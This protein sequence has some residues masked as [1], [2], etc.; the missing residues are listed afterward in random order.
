MYIEELGESESLKKI[1]S[2]MVL[3][4]L[5]VSIITLA[6]ELQPIKGW[7]GTVCIRADGSIDP[8]DAPIITYDRITYTLTDNITSGGD[9]IIVERDNIIIDGNGFT[10][11]GWRVY[12]PKGIYLSDSVNV[13]AQKIRIKGFCYGIYLNYSSS[14]SIAG[15]GITESLYTGIVLWDSS[16]YNS[17]VGNNI[18]AIDYDGIYVANS[19]NNHISR[20][21][22]AN[23]SHSIYMWGTSSNSTIYHNNFINTGPAEDPLGYK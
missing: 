3:A 23:N 19:S 10:L 5:L 2:G 11:E 7:T 21:N 14:N 15:N 20:N 1:G 18:T 17:I 12:P 16:N 8:E 22:I 13:T 4:L 9:G 6:F